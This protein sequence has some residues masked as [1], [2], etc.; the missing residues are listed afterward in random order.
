MRYF[1]NKYTDKTMTILEI[2]AKNVQRMISRRKMNRALFWGYNYTGMDIE[3]GKHI[4]IV[5]Y[6]NITKQYDVVISGQTM[7]HVNHPWDWLKNLTNYYTQYICIIA[8]HRWGEHRFPLDTYR[9]FPDG[10]RDLFEYAGIKEIEILKG[11]YD[12]MGIGGK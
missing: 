6:E 2:G 12:T 1:R 7:E 4:D 11:R 3:P 8:P 10:M 5:G 9:Y